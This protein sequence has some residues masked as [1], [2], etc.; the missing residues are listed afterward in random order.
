[1]WC[2][3][4]GWLYSLAVGLAA[5]DGDRGGSSR[6]LCVSGLLGDE[7]HTS[8]IALSGCDADSLYIASV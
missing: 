3:G 8:L 4:S 6:A 2:G 5:V 7:S 1:M